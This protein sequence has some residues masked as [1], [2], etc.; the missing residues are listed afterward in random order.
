MTHRVS[1]AVMAKMS[2]DRD[3]KAITNSNIRLELPEGHPAKR[4]T[5]SRDQSRV[6]NQIALGAQT[7]HREAARTK[8]K[9]ARR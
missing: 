9:S 5:T 4:A 6:R 2:P 3:R 7:N 1:A 8:P